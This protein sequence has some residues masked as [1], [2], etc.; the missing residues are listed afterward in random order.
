M[1]NKDQEGGGV[2]THNREAKKRN[3]C[4]FDQGM[5]V[6]CVIVCVMCVWLCVCKENVLCLG[7][8]TFEALQWFPSSNACPELERQS[9]QRDIFVIYFE[10]G[11]EAWRLGVDQRREWVERREYDQGPNIKMHFEL[12]MG[13]EGKDIEDGIPATVGKTEEAAGVHSTRMSA[14]QRDSGR[15]EKVTMT[16]TAGQS[17]G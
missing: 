12:E 17:Q 6:M 15:R 13:R 7:F 1:E 5:C 10:E 11:T 4:F 16:N 14:Q 9:G 8:I 2:I 3:S